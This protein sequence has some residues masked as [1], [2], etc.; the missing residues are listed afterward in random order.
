MLQTTG[1]SHLKDPIPDL[2]VYAQWSGVK[3]KIRP[4]S[5]THVHRKSRMQTT[6]TH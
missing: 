1:L 4:A 3:Y 2:H 6:P 5:Y